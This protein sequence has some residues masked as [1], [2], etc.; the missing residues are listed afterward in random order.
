MRLV[1]KASDK[2]DPRGGRNQTAY[3]PNH[4]NV[5]TVEV[6]GN[7]SMHGILHSAAETECHDDRAVQQGRWHTAMVGR[8]K[9]NTR[10]DFV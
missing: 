3:C 5:R 7:G 4:N 10:R 2:E 9:S 6:D 1:V 8:A